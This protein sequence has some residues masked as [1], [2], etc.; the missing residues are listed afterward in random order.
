MALWVSILLTVSFST[1]NPMIIDTTISMVA[2]LSGLIGALVSAYLGYVVRI[3]VKERG[4][5]EHRKA[6][7]H[8]HF[9]QL[10]DFVASDFYLKEF[11]G[12]IS[13]EY[14]PNSNDFALS[15]KAAA[16]LAS[17]IAALESDAL[18]Q[19]HGLLKPII[20]V[21]TESMDRFTL[22]QDQ[23]AE[24]EPDTIYVYNRYVTSSLRLKTSLTLIESLLEKGD[25]KLLDASILHGV[26]LSYRTFADASGV[27]RAAFKHAAGVSDNYSFQCLTRS[28]TA[29][30]KDVRS[31]FENSSQLE[32]AKK[33][34]TDTAE[35]NAVVQ[36]D[37]TR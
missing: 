21:S 37:A 36:G 31:S 7:A 2:L 23:L 22:S 24:L 27:L 3:K 13:K 29:I 17:K 14:E 34:A 26:F 9:L 25:P 4:D 30:Q 18:K 16:F 8:V 32:K 20:T 19:V 5:Q 35:A 10:T 15:H 11:L 6:V 1:L 33:A 28:Y 12:R